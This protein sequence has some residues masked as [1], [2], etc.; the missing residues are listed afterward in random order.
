MQTEVLYGLNRGSVFLKQSRCSGE[1]MF[2]FERKINY[3][4]VERF[5]ERCFLLATFCLLAVYDVLKKACRTQSG[6]HNKQ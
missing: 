1:I 2:L 6:T 4:I 3:K 5:L